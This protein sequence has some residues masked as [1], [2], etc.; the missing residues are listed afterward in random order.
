VDKKELL[1]NEFIKG[2][3]SRRDFNAGLMGMGLTAAAASTFISATIKEAEAQ[4]PKKGGHLLVATQD[5]TAGGTID[6]ILMVNWSD[7]D[8]NGPLSNRLVES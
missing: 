2:K 6:P 7:L 5:D 4:A 1:K 8:R 3:V